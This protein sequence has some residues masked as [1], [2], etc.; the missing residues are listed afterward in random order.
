M[1]MPGCFRHIIKSGSAKE[2]EDKQSKKLEKIENIKFVR[3]K[4]VFV[5]YDVS[6]F[7]NEDTCTDRDW[8]NFK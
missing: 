5:T 2:S 6:P 8:K 4:I 3:Q 1:A 7:S